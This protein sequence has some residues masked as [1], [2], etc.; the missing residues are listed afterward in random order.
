MSHFLTL[1]FLEKSSVGDKRESPP[2]DGSA[3]S[4]ESKRPRLDTAVANEVSASPP[5]Q[6][7]D[8]SAATNGESSTAPP[9]ATVESANQES[10]N[11]SDPSIEK[12]E[13]IAETPLG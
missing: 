1:K 10:A 9:S 3:E 12:K 11:G 4:S 13:N 8:Q 5:P 6:E 7:S 2:E